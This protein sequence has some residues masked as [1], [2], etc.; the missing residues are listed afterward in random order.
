MCELTTEIHFSSYYDVCHREVTGY[1]VLFRVN[2]LKT[3]ENMFPNLAVIRGEQLI[4]HYAL[5]IYEL[6]DLAEVS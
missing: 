2:G 1:M 3:L 6:M 5:I 4:K